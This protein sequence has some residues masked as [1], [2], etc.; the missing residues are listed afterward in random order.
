MRIARPLLPLLL[1]IP[2]W[3]SHASSP[4][5]P[6]VLARVRAAHRIFVSN[7]G[8]DDTL[9][10]IGGHGMGYLDLYQQLAGWPGIQLVGSPAQADLIFQV[11]GDS[12]KGYFDKYSTYTEHVT[13]L[14]PSTH[15]VLWFNDCDPTRIKSALKPVAPRKPGP[16]TSKKSPRTTK[17][18]Q[19]ALH[20]AAATAAA[21]R[22]VRGR[23]SLLAGHRQVRGLHVGGYSGP[24]RSHPFPRCRPTVRSPQQQQPAGLWHYPGIDFGSANEDDLMDLGE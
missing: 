14:D 18:P 20:P 4:A 8:E 2:S 3:Q 15:Q 17:E 10:L 6:G 1:V 9:S 16:N 7:A 11:Y 21:T 5:P 22:S 13:I 23:R 19:K 24:G 12:S